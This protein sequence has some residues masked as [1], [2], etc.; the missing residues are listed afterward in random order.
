MYRRSRP[1]PQRS[2]RR[3]RRPQRYTNP[4]TEFKPLLNAGYFI[5]LHYG[6]YQEDYDNGGTKIAAY[7][8]YER[9][10]GKTP[11][12]QGL[13]LNCQENKDAFQPD[14]WKTCTLKDNQKCQDPNDPTKL[15]AGLT[16]CWLKDTQRLIPSLFKC[17]VFDTNTN[18][19][20]P[21]GYFNPDNYGFSKKYNRSVC[22]IKAKINENDPTQRDFEFECSVDDGTHAPD[23]TKQE[24]GWACVGF[25]TYAAPTDYLGGCID[26]KAEQVCGTTKDNETVTYIKHET[27][28]YGLVRAYAPCG[29]SNGKG[30]CDKARRVCTGGNWLACDKCDHCPQTTTGQQTICPGG[31]WPSDSCKAPQRPYQRD[32]RWSR[33]R[34]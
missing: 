16:H 12:L 4:T 27:D 31:V 32:L 23:P 19:D 5:E 11:A 22:N 33:Q 24:V 15:K 7:H 17:A 26:E 14:Y 29:T 21:E 2:R 20:I 28:S 8:V 18:K 30:E 3:H 34:L 1:Q 13:A 9:S 6:N 10:R 25:Q